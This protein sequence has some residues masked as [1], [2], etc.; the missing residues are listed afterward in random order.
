M[1]VCLLQG[2]IHEGQFRRIP[3]GFNGSAGAQRI[4]PGGPTKAGADYLNGGVETGRRSDR[5]EL[6]KALALCRKQKAKLVIAK[7]DRLSRNLALVPR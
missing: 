5:P 2:A 1:L 3:P 6:A 7:L 4:G